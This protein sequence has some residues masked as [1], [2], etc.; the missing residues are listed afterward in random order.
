M[1]SDTTNAPNIVKRLAVIAKLKTQPYRRISSEQYIKLSLARI[2]N[3][4][5]MSIS[6]SKLNVWNKNIYVDYQM[7]NL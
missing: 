1:I 6:V 5:R 7:L 3:Y 2:F 4:S